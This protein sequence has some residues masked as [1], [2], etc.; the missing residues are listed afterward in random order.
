[1]GDLTFNGVTKPVT[2]EA[3][4]AGSGT[5]MMTQKETVGFHGT[6][7]IM[8]SEFGMGWGVEYGLGDEVELNISIA[9]EKQ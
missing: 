7:T 6:A 5:N 1:M 3:E 2:I 8:R 9:F 4:L